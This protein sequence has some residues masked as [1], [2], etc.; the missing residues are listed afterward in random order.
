MIDRGAT[1]TLVA[2]I[3][4]LTLFTNVTKGLFGETA[5]LV[6]DALFLVGAALL[7]YLPTI[8]YSKLLGLLLGYLAAHG[9]AQFLT[10]GGFFE[11]NYTDYRNFM[12][13][14]VI[15]LLLLNTRFDSEDEV[16]RFFSQLFLLVGGVILA[17]VFLESLAYFV[18]NFDLR[19]L[20]YVEVA[21][22]GIETSYGDPNSRSRIPTL[23]GA[24]QPLGL[25][26]AG[27]AFVYWHLT[28]EG[29]IS[30]RWFVLALVS[31]LLVQSRLQ[32]FVVFFVLLWL[33]LR[34][35]RLTPR[36]LVALGVSAV[37]A[38]VVVQ[39]FGHAFLLTEHPEFLLAYQAVAY[40]G[41]LEPLLN[42]VML[43]P[44]DEMHKLLFGV[45]AVT[46]NQQFESVINLAY[47][48]MGLIVEL[49]PRYGLTLVVLYYS[50]L[51][52]VFRRLRSLGHERLSLALIPFAAAPLHM[53][54]VNLTFVT[55]MFFFILAYC[56]VLIRASYTAGELTE[57]R[58]VETGAAPA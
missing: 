42:L 31:L 52:V 9:F 41:S 7:V 17:N 38:L 18:L 55:D 3:L 13:G 11:Y 54:L 30:N 12:R 35:V 36:R 45:G 14:G 51:W 33:N 21:Y 47:V 46:G 50:L 40:T 49:I 43:P 32:I 1:R 56:L 39:R 23:L 34:A 53:W 4:L 58:L 26:Q 20:F 25:V 8:R 2:A 6:V 37:L 15:A 5:N 44:L 22:R 27:V 16:N 10:Y 28:R 57:A 24:P 29:Y 48:E 19:S